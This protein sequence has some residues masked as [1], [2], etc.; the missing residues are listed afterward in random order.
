MDC[1]VLYVLLDNSG[2]I[3]RYNED[4]GLVYMAARLAGGYAAVLRALNEVYYSM[5]ILAVFSLHFFCRKL[6]F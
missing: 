6:S 4:L 2:F 3:L 5:H 1:E